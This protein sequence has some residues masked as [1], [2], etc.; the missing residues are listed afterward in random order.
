MT[1]HFDAWLLTHKIKG[2]N[3]QTS[4]S[5]DWH[6]DISDIIGMNTIGGTRLM[7]VALNPRQ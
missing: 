3:L 4:I 7:Q 6:G 1:E 2:E 5:H